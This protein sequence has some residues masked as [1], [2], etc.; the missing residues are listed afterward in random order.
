MDLVLCYYFILPSIFSLNISLKSSVQFP[1]MIS[2]GTFKCVGNWYAFQFEYYI[3]Y[4]N[5]I[6]NANDFFGV[7]APTIN[8]IHCHGHGPNCHLQKIHGN[9]ACI[10][11]EIFSLTTHILPLTTHCSHDSTP[12]L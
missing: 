10:A 4:D 9:N 5:T 3:D 8:I 6:Y 7:N 11:I 2:F 1:Y 12:H